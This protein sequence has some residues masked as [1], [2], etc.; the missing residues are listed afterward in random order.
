MT[1]PCI[2][3]EV[4]MRLGETQ[5]DLKGAMAAVATDVSHIRKKVD[6]GL[7]TELRVVSGELHAVER[8]L[9][10]FIA[11]TGIKDE[12]T[13]IAFVEQQAKTDKENFFSRI[14]SNSMTKLIGLAFGFIIVNS[15]FNSGLGLFL[16]SQI[17]KE[18]A[19]Q[20]ESIMNKTTDIQSTLNV[21]HHHTLPDGRLLSHTGDPNVPAWIFNPKT[22]IWEKAPTM[23]TEAGIK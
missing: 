20:Q 10:D 4:I 9:A 1:E 17:S 5:G 12:R 18:P 8:A 11:A 15:A 22:S 3:Q 21:P 13:K 19:G 16:K 6:N 7:S 23:R 14:F 2:M